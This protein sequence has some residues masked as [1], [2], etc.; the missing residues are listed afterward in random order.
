MVWRAK[1][2]G[3]CRRDIVSS[4]STRTLPTTVQKVT[5]TFLRAGTR[6]WRRS[7][8]TGSSTKPALPVSLAPGCSA[9]GSAIERP[10]PMKARRSVS[11][12][13]ARCEPELSSTKC[14]S[15]ITA[16]SDE[17]GR[18]RAKITLLSAP[19]SVSTNIFAK[20]GCAL[21]A[22]SGASASSANDVTSIWRSASPSF[23][24]VMRRPSPCPSDTTMHST[25]DRIAP[26]VLT[27]L[28]LASLKWV[29]AVSPSMLFG[30][31]RRR[32]PRAAFGVA[33]EQEG[34]HPI[35]GR[36]G[37]PAGDADVAEAAVAGAGRR[38]HH[39]ILAVRHH[40]GGFQRLRRVED[41]P[42]I[43]MLGAT[44]TAPRSAASVRTVEMRMSRGAFSCSSSSAASIT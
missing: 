43:G 6:T 1:L 35:L 25:S 21:S 22:S 10:R 4:T 27:K 28:A 8:I 13:V 34:A 17:R 29:C 12:S 3:C 37:L 40:V 38:H 36:I 16:S 39:R 15:S 41:Q 24:I 14:A 32:P 23:Q 26:A 44:S 2:S 7:E 31:G 11:A 30:V 18:R 20:A 5:D 19:I 9:A 42:R 33:K